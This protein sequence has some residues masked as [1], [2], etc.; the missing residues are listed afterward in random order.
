M[1]IIYIGEVTYSQKYKKDEV[2]EFA[3][4]S[5]KKIEEENYTYIIFNRFFVYNKETGKI[6]FSIDPN[7]EK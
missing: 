7:M 6:D 3:G 5:F 1:K 2:P 4:G